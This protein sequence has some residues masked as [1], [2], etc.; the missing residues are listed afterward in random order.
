MENLVSRRR[1]VQ[2]DAL[3]LALLGLCSLWL[4]NRV[5]LYLPSPE[6]FEET[7]RIDGVRFAL[8]SLLGAACLSAALARL[9]GTPTGKVGSPLFSRL[10][11]VAWFSL[12]LW[13]LC[14]ILEVQLSL[15]H[16][17]W[18]THLDEYRGLLAELQMP[19]L[20]LASLAAVAPLASSSRKAIAIP[21]RR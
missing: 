17:S 15:A 7:G 2:I 6:L 20:W 3:V 12:A 8:H 18:K 14:A 1:R 9:I 21:F 5:N 13:V 4:A 19:L 10:L 16:P 11:S